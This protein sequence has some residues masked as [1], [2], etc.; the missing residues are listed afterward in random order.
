MS[1]DPP[2]PV[3]PRTPPEILTEIAEY[4]STSGAYFRSATGDPVDFIDVNTLARYIGYTLE[5]LAVLIR[6]LAASLAAGYDFEAWVKDLAEKG[7][8]QA[9]DLA[10]KV[11]K[12]LDNLAG[13]Y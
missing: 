2:E 13:A 11:L 3:P 5:P 1:G 4:L 8:P 10:E 6:E 7:T 9:R 12:A